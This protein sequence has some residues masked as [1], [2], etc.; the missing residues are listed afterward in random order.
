MT[1]IFDKV[2]QPLTIRQE[3]ESRLRRLAHAARST[4][5]AGAGR[6]HLAG[7]RRRRQEA[8]SD[9]RTF[10]IF[11]SQVAPDMLVVIPM[12]MLL[13]G[14]MFDLSVTGVANLSVV[15]VGWTFSRLLGQMDDTLLIISWLSRSV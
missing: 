2:K 6:L 3:E 15:L 10:P 12:A 14:G 1:A 8:S 13:I 4:V 5:A 9:R 11:L 7:A